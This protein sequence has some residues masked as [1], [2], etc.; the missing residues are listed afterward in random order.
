MRIG[1]VLPLFSGDTETA[2]GAYRDAVELLV[3]DEP[4][5]ALAPAAGLFLCPDTALPAPFPNCI[6]C[7]P[8]DSADLR[9]LP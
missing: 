3:G 1:L 2:E 5:A 6:F 7:T 8:E 4:F 9:G